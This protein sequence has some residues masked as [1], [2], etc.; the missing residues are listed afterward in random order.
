M[1]APSQHS[2]YIQYTVPITTN[3]ID[4]GDII[5]FR[6]DGKERWALVL[7]PLWKGKMHALSLENL[8]RIVLQRVSGVIYEKSSLVLYETYLSK[9]KIITDAQSYRTFDKNKIIGPRQVA[10]DFGQNAVEPNTLVHYGENS[11]ILGYGGNNVYA[12]EYPTLRGIVRTTGRKGVFISGVEG[13]PDL[14]KNYVTS[15]GLKPNFTSW[16][17]QPDVE[18]DALKLEMQQ[19]HLKRLLGLG[20]VFFSTD[21]EMKII[22]GLS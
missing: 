7:T 4:R 5:T 1:A 17:L 3:Q 16:L 9:N 12:A 18:D 21:D 11:L 10:Y 6:Y 14:V 19:S 20:G 2:R 22:R 15:V 13:V 8:T